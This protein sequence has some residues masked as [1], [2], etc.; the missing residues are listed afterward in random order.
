MTRSNNQFYLTAKQLEPHPVIQREQS[1][2]AA[3]QMAKDF[4]PDVLGT[5]HAVPHPSAL[6][7]YLIIDGATRW[8]AAKL[9]GYAGD[10][11][12]QV[13]EGYTTKEIADISR[14]LNKSRKW[15]AADRHNIDVLRE[16]PK[17]VEIQAIVSKYQWILGRN[18][19]TNRITCPAQVYSAFDKLSAEGLDYLIK[20]MTSIYGHDS[21]AFQGKVVEAYTEFLYLYRSLPIFDSTRMIG[22]YGPDDLPWKNIK[23]RVDSKERIKQR[24][25]N[26]PSSAIDFIRQVY[27]L[28][29]RVELKLP[30]IGE[31]RETRN[32]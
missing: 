3:K 25:Y 9:V 21:D 14:L 17:A 2:G 1:Q 5:L 30:T 16:D 29:Q 6:E 28:R 11:C 4:N 31:I 20:M 15:E 10:L 23:T 22:S 8:A 13:Y 12:V 24:I 7:T 27:N 18:K 26:P 19:S 32:L